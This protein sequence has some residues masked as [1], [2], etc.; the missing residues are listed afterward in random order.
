[1]QLYPKYSW[2]L[3]PSLH[4]STD[5]DEWVGYLH[6]TSAHVLWPSVT[7]LTTDATSSTL[8]RI[9]SLL[10]LS[11]IVTED[12]ESTVMA[13]GTPSSSVLAYLFPIDVPE[14][15]R[16]K[17]SLQLS[18]GSILWGAHFIITNHISTDHSL[19][20]YRSRNLNCEIICHPG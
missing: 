4:S 14:K 1:M 9:W 6:S 16:K 17:K 5:A 7:S 12:V 8:T 19:N 3:E 15:K 11:L 10:S 13:R 20:R 2:G 18:N